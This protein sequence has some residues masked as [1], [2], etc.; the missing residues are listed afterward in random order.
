MLKISRQQ[1]LAFIKSD[2]AFVQWYTESFMPDNLPHFYH[3]IENAMLRRMVLNGRRIAES[4]GFPDPNTQAHFITFMWSVGANFF[5]FPIFAAIINRPDLQPTEKID[6][7]Y[8]VD[9]DAA[10]EVI[11]QAD[12]G[13]WFRVPEKTSGDA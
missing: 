5:E 3:D 10:A 1:Q 12:D 6:R 11:L 2:E 13:A 4:K 8:E 9:G 7:L